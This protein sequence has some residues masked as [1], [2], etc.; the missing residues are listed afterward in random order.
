MTSVYEVLEHARWVERQRKAK[1]KRST[2]AAKRFYSSWAWKGLRYRIL[3]ERG[4][5]CECC[6][7][8]AE[9]GVRIVVDHI[10]PLRKFWHLRLDPKN[11]QVL[12]DD[13]NRG[14]SGHDVTDWREAPR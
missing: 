13:C 12:C 5:R 9:D 7:A 2:T 10:Q 8:T 11:C 3:K 6:N 1:K 4:R 14:K